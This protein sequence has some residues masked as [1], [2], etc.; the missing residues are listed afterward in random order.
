MSMYEYIMLVKGF[1]RSTGRL[2]G[3]ENHTIR[4]SRFDEADVT[5]SGLT[6]L[7]E[8]CFENGLS[9]FGSEFMKLLA[10]F[11]S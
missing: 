11:G 7:F 6:P 4:R 1:L 10:K 5:T 3:G 8:G 9:L 2:K